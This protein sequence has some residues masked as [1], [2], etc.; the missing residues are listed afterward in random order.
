MD[1]HPSYRFVENLMDKV[2]RR[3]IHEHPSWLTISVISGTDQ[4]NI[5]E[6]LE[7]FYICALQ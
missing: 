2:L 4:Q 3:G 7:M 5:S 6:I 1:L